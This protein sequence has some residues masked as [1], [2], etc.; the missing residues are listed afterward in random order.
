MAMRDH[1]NKA[2]Y[3]LRR[4]AI[5]EYSALAAATP[6]CVRLTLGEPDFDTPEEV[7]AA[8]VRSIESGETHYIENNGKRELRQKI[9][10]FERESSGLDYDPDEIIV[11]AGATE[12]I[13]TSLM[14]ILD[15]GD[16]VIVPKPAFVLYEEIIHLA[17][18]ECVSL[19]TS[20]SRFQIREEDLAPLITDR[21]KAVILNSPNNPTGCVY[22]EESLRIV[23]EAVRGR[24]I[25]VICDDVYR[26]LYYGQAYHSFAEYSDIREQIIVVQSFSK[27][28]AMTGWRT[29]YLMADQSVKER[30]ELIHQFSVVSTP[31]MFQ[32]ACMTAL[33]TE[34]SEMVTEYR[35]RR[36]YVIGRLRKMG[37]ETETPE[38]AFYAFPS[39]RKYG[40]GSGDF[41]RRL[42]REAGAA[43]TPGFAFG[44]DEHI[45]ISYCCSRE[46]LREGL[47]RLERFLQK[48]E[49]ERSGAEV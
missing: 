41:A 21:T 42:I 12:A 19:D 6:G 23:Y 15:P 3:A 30:L 17:R 43:V 37:L 8:A 40:L 11:T 36:D 31:A 14:G 24:D 2:V 26:Q 38:G 45:R 22:D 9:A 32:E 47:D 27:P 18:A 39:I 46:A 44:S 33:D 1:M 49:E 28:Y 20:G 13:F 29:G 5:R 25:F 4:S 34:P 16:E 35:A 10:A 48:L 7:R